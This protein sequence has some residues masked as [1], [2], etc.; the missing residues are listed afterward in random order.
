MSKSFAKKLRIFNKCNGDCYYCGIPLN[1]STWNIDHRIPT[2]KGGGNG[3]DNLVPSCS[4]CNLSKNNCKPEE[5]KSRIKLRPIELL[6]KVLEK[7]EHIE[8]QTGLDLEKE[9]LSIE[10]IIRRIE[11]IKIKFHGEKTA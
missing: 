9:L 8:R 5:F 2:S 3:I 11:Q 10:A 4:F 1:P 7:I 6:E